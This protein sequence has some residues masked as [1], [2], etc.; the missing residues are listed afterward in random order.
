MFKFVNFKGTSGNFCCL[1]FP[2]CC[3]YAHV[4]SD[5]IPHYMNV[6]IQISREVFLAIK[7]TSNIKQHLNFNINVLI[8]L[9]IMVSAIVIL[10]IVY[11]TNVS[12]RRLKRMHQATNLLTKLVALNS[13][14]EKLKLP[15]L[16]CSIVITLRYQ[17]HLYPTWDVCFAC[18]R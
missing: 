14:V 7:T 16:K 2:F 12:Y 13:S 11:P 4:F 17:T 1:Y 18:F 8:F 10:Q 9:F 3:L 5:H 15:L 6:Y